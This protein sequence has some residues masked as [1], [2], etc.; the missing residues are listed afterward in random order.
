MA[1]EFGSTTEKER[2]ASLGHHSPDALE[3]ENDRC[4]NDNPRN[5]PFSSVISRRLLSRTAE[6]GT[7]GFDL[8]S[9]QLMYHFEHFTSE[10]LLFDKP[11]WEK[12]ILPLALQ[13]CRLS[14]VPSLG[15]DLG[16]A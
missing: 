16:V 10:T 11:F 12:H 5:L 9:L 2:T 6:L 7:P 3:T 13:V 15:T 1:C 14:C 4:G 8:D